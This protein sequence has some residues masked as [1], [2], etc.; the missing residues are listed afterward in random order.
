MLHNAVYRFADRE[1]EVAFYVP[2]GNHL[3]AAALRLRNALLSDRTVRL[4]DRFRTA[5]PDVIESDLAPEEEVRF[6]YVLHGEAL[7]VYRGTTEIFRG[8]VYV[9]VNQHG[10]AAW[11]RQ[12]MAGTFEPFRQ[13]A[14]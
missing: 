1:G 10:P 13:I 3:E 4:A 9:F 11:E 14:I 7:M 12:G 8:P 5:N 6:T 2:I